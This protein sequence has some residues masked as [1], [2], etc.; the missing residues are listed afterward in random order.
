MQSVTIEIE[1]YRTDVHSRE[2]ELPA[3]GHPIAQGVFPLLISYND[4]LFPIG[5]AFS[6]GRGVPFIVSAAHN[7]YEAWKYEPRLAHR[8]LP[9]ELP[10]SI[11]LKHAGLS[12]SYHRVDDGGRI[13]FSVWPL[14]TVAGAPPTD[15]VFGSLKFRT[16]CPMLVHPLSFDLPTIGEKVWSI[17]YSA[18]TFPKNGIPLAAVRRGSFDWQNEY[19]HKLMVVEGVVQRI[20]IQRFAAGFVEGPCLTID[21][22]I[23]HAQSGGPVLSPDGLVR[24]VSSAGATEFFNSPTSIASLLYP[25]L[26]SELRFGASIGPVRI[27]ASRTLVDLIGQGI[28][29]TDGSEERVGIQ[30]DAI[31]GAPSVN[32]RAPKAMS[33]FI[34]DDFAGF[35]NT[36]AATPH[37]GTAFRLRRNAPLTPAMIEVTPR[38]AM[39]TTDSKC[40]T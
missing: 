38:L 34:F 23:A 4:H 1:K 19:S 13:R 7:I 26:F 31:T 33:D 10:E 25:T 9:R 6:I 39:T 3:W 5:T 30:Q 27:N 28:I 11:D 8:A 14:E 37:A 40:R 16:D 22:E 36:K 2:W 18:F 29:K 20:F 21:A 24:G 32:P 15:V 12:I 35:Q 17:G